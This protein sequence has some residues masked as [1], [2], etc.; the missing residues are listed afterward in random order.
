MPHRILALLL[1]RDYLQDYSILEPDVA[2]QLLRGNEYEIKLKDHALEHA[3]FLKS[4]P[5][6]LTLIDE[7]MSAHGLSEYLHKCARQV[8]LISPKGGMLASF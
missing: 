5:R 3:V 1:K 7:P 8:G 2:S 6:G 4:T